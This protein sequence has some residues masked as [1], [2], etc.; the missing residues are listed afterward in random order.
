M[1]KRVIRVL[2]SWYP[3]SFGAAS[4]EIPGCVAAA[5][6]LDDV[7][8]EFE[9]GLQFHLEGL[10]PDEVPEC[11]KGE[12]QLEYEYTTQALLHRYDGILTRA[13]LSRITGIDQKIL[14]HYMTGYRTPRPKRR[15]QIIDGLHRLGSELLAAY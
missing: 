11:L 9:E 10:E 15:Q 2:I 7:I 8:R 1:E 5:E 4:D 3:G 14:G 12:Y 13:A 6:K